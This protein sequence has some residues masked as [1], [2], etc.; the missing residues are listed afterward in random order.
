VFARPFGVD[1]WPNSY[2]LSGAGSTVRAVQL[3]FFAADSQP[4]GLADLGGLLAGP[5]QIVR[6]GSAA[7]LSVV[8]DAPA[9]QPSWRAD[10]L[11]A[12]FAECGVGGDIVGT[13]DDL[14]AVRT[15]FRSTLLPL[16]EAWARGAMKAPP[17][18]FVLNGPRLRL[19][20]IS[21]GRADDHGYL[22]TV[23]DSDESTWSAIGTA[24]GAAGVPGALLGPRAGGPAFRVTSQRRLRRLREYVGEPPEGA[25]DRDWPPP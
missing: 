1:A 10:A 8:L 16:A 23:G 20:A 15:D 5:G 17:R 12:A 19:W 24:L 7:R 9:G 6:S 21:A 11:L 18:G 14:L 22:L 13:V 3:S 2:P 25:T 4:V